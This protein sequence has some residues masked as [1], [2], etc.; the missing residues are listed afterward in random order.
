MGN[1]DMA[2]SSLGDTNQKSVNAQGGSPRDEQMCKA[3][4]F[5]ACQNPKK[6]GRL[7]FSLCGFAFGGKEVFGIFYSVKHMLN[8]CKYLLYELT[9]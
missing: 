4:V 5:L 8:T 3:V 1:F 2:G 6:E 9:N 7:I